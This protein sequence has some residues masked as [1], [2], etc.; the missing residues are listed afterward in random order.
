VHGE[1]GAGARLGIVRMRGEAPPGSRLVGGSQV[2][3]WI[4]PAADL[5][6]GI[7]ITPRL[8]LRASAELG[9][10]ATG[11]TA[12]DFGVRV[13]ALAGTWTSLGLAAALE[14]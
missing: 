13:A 1:L 11:A 7:D 2:R 14:L 3:P 6:V 9:I 10:V 8:S 5:A 4:G 12:R